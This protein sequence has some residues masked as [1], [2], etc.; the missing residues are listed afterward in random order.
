VPDS[1]AS[2]GIQITYTDKEAFC[3]YRLSELFLSDLKFC[4]LRLF[5]R[6]LCWSIAKEKDENKGFEKRNL[7]SEKQQ[8]N[9]DD[10]Q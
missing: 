1:E 3:R 5:Y 10:T 7:T 4:G 8:E 2:N 6:A 9:R